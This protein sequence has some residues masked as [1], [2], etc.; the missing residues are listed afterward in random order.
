[1]VPLGFAA[2]FKTNVAAKKTYERQSK[3]IMRKME[4]VNTHNKNQPPKHAKQTMPPFR[5]HVVGNDFERLVHERNET[6]RNTV[7]FI[8]DLKTKRLD[9]IRKIDL[10]LLYSA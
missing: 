8:I 3:T 2:Q 5:C 7:F 4:A 1:M 10:D 9:S 6:C